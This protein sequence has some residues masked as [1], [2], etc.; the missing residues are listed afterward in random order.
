MDPTG[1][2]PRKTLECKEAIV[3]DD[4]LS[5]PVYD[6]IYEF[7]CATDYEHINTKGKVARVWRVRDGFPLRTS[8]NLF[9]FTD[10]RRKPAGPW[11]YPTATALDRFVDALNARMSEVAHFVGQP[12]RDWDR[13]SV[14]GWRYPRETGLSLHD[15]GSETYSAAYVYF[16]HP[17][18]D[19]HW[20]GLLVLLDAAANARLAAHKRDRDALAYYRKKWAD[21]TDENALVEEPGLARCVFP[22]RNRLVL[23]AP[24]AY[25]LVTKVNIDAGDTARLSLAG[26][27]MKPGRGDAAVPVEPPVTG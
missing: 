23:I 21:P 15:D 4:F 27:F 13:F 1:P 22:R 26:F 8:L 24:D 14:T 3:I 20:G 12:G 10:E 9:Y 25:H 7:L 19:I 11:V 18:W 2:A 5:E 6:E 16:V 17:R